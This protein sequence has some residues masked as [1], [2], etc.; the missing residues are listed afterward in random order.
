ML[1]LSIPVQA[2]WYSVGGEIFVFARYRLEGLCMC[3]VCK[4]VHSHSSLYRDYVVMLS[5]GLDRFLC[6][7]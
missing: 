2:A 1:A 6:L 7:P 4:A 5:C 3:I